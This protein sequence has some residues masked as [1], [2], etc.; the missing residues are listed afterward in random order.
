M[1]LVVA[2]VKEQLLALLGF[3]LLF[4]RS[5]EVEVLILVCDLILLEAIVVT[6]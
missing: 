1:V 6:L 5:G 3:L 2:A 4:L